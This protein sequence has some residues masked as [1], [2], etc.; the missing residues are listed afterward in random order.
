MRIVFVLQALSTLLFGSIIGF[1]VVWELMLV[2][3][4]MIIIHG[5]TI[6][7]IIYLTGRNS[8]VHSRIMQKAGMVF[9]FSF[10]KKVVKMIFQR[11]ISFQI[12][13]PEFLSHDLFIQICNI[14]LPF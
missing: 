11:K 7:G 4:I 12:D 5:L 14:D 8:S 13:R 6:A 10:D 9:V 1:L 3:W 2:V